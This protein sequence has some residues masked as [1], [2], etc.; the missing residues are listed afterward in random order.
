MTVPKAAATLSDDGRHSSVRRQIAG[1]TAIMMA[2][3][4]GSRIAGLF[5]ER[6]IAH[7]FGQGYSTDIYNGAF[8]IPDLM[9]FLIAGGAL[10]SAF[11]PVFS[12][13]IAKNKE[14]E[15]WRIFSAVALVMTIVVTALIIV[16]EI[17]TRTLVIWTNP[18][19]EQ[20]PGKVE[21]TAALTQ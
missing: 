7:Q 13:Y 12:E 20:I 11:I 5:R 8:T 14:R 18:G 15:A 6:I 2:G 19:F 9:F 17:F 21:A 1:G 3:I 16:G 4:L 10:S